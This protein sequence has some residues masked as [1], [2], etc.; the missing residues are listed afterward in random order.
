MK[1]FTP[2][3]N[4]ILEN[5]EEKAKMSR[6]EEMLAHTREMMNADLDKKVANGEMDEHEAREHYFHLMMLT[7]MVAR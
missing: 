4:S 6:M 7:M 2:E 5:E 3:V 1:D